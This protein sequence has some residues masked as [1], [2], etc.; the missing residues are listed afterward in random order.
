MPDEADRA[1]AALRADPPP[2][3]EAVAALPREPGLVAWWATRPFPGVDGDAG[4][5][6]LVVGPATSLR[7]RVTRQDLFRT[8]VSGLR[9]TLAGLLLDEL[10]LTPVWAAE[11]VLPR[12]QEDVL[13]DWMRTRLRLSWWAGERRRELLDPVTD[14]LA[15]A[16][17]DDRDPAAAAQARFAA[18]AGEKPVREVGVPYRRP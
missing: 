5:V 1:I 9:R 2:L 12:A 15:P 16:L 4:E 6:A 10:E 17:R 11:V 14:A 8:G 18:A 3:D 13:T 7:N